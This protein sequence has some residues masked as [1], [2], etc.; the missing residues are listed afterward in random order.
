MRTI[1]EKA[2]KVLND[3]YHKDDISMK[4]LNILVSYIDYLKGEVENCMNE[5]NKEK[6][7]DDKK[8]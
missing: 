6:K 8:H 2:Q 4:E 1:E 5:R 3:L 7:N